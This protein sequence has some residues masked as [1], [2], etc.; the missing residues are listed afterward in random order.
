MTLHPPTAT[1]DQKAQLQGRSDPFGTAT[2]SK[3]LVSQET[4]VAYMT[5]TQKKLTVFLCPKFSRL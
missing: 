3:E 2:K 1:G 5:A 4:S